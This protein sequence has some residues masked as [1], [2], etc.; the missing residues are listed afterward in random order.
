[1]SDLSSIR[2]R[3]FIVICFC[4]GI[5]A[6][7]TGCAIFW[8]QVQPMEQPAKKSIVV[9]PLEA[10]WNPLARTPEMEGEADI[11]YQNSSNGST[12]SFTSGCRNNSTGEREQ[13]LEKIASSLSGGITRVSSRKQSKKF[14]DGVPALESTIEGT[15]QGRSL[16]IRT[17]VARK[18]GCVYDVT[19]VA[20][21][22]FFDSSSK[23]FEDWTSQIRL[24]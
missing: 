8:G 11:S 2:I 14:L 23:N 24:P 13:E 20:L 18:E 21:K 16:V 5:P 10:P 19:L 15:F 17:R 6:I 1:M 4:L 12:L 22:R 9:P 3:R 7:N